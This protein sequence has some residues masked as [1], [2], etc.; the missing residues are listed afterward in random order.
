[1]KRLTLFILLQALLMLCSTVCAESSYVTIGDGTNSTYFYGYGAG[2]YSTTQTIYTAEEI[3]KEGYITAL[4][5]NVA[6]ASAKTTTKLEIYLGLTLKEAFEDANDGL[7]ADELTLVYSGNPTLGST[8]GWNDHVF[9]TKFLFDGTS[10]LVVVV[11]RE[12]SSNPPECYYSNSNGKKNLYRYDFYSKTYSELQ[13]LDGYYTSSSRQNTRFLIEQFPTITVNNINY[14]VTSEDKKTV[15]VAPGSYSGIVSIPATVTYNGNSYS[16][17]SV[18]KDA[19]SG[20]TGLTY[21]VLGNN[22]KTIGANAFKG[23]TGLTT[24]KLPTQLETIGNYAFYDCQNCN[25]SALS[26]KEGL[27]SIGDFAFYNCDKIVSISMPSTLTHL[28]NNAFQN[29]DQLETAIL[30]DALNNISDYCFE[31]CTN[32]STLHLPDNALSIGNSAFYCCSK[33]T[34]IDIPFSV[35]TIGDYALNSTGLSSLIVPSNVTT[36]GTRAFYSS[37]L[38]EVTIDSPILE[39]NYTRSSYGANTLCNFFGNKVEK[40]IIGD[41][42]TRIGNYAFYSDYYDGNKCLKEV[43]MG[44]NIKEVGDYAFSSC[45]AIEKVYYTSLESLCSINFISYNSNPAYYNTANVYIAGEELVGDLII[46]STITSI[47]SYAFYKANI[48]SVNIPSSVISIGKEAFY[49]CSNLSKL[50]IDSPD[51][52]GQDYESYEGIIGTLFGYKITEVVIGNTPTKIGKKAFYSLTQNQLASVKFGNNIREI[53]ESAFGNRET[54]SKVEF[55]SIAALCETTFGNN[56]ANP[57]YCAKNLY[58]NGE[59]V[60]NAVIPDGVTSISNYAFYNAESIRSIDIP[61]SVTSIG[62]ASFSGCSN[63]EDIYVHWQYPPVITGYGGKYGNL[64]VPIGMKSNYSTKNYWKSFTIIADQDYKTV[65]DIQFSELCYRCEIGEI[66]QVEFS[67]YPEDALIKDVVIESDGSSAIYFD[68]NTRQFVGLEDGVATITV[69]SRDKDA[70]S[71]SIKI[72]V[73][74]VPVEDAISLDRNSLN[75]RVGYND[76]LTVSQITTNGSDKPV[77]WTSSNTSVATVSNGVVTG[78]GEGIATITASISGGKSATCT[79][80]VY[81]LKTAITDGSSNTYTN[82]TTE[83]YDQISYTRNYSNTKW[84]SLYVPFTMRYEDWKDEYD[85]AYI[86]SVRQYDNDNDG[87]IDETIMDV[88]QIT[89]GEL[90][91]NMPYMIRA[92]STGSKTITL[93]N[94]ILYQTEVNSVSC[95]TILSEFTF[96][97]TYTTIDAATMLSNNYYAMGGG[98]LIK[99]NGTSSL[100]PFRW[101][102]GIT[103]RSPIYN[104]ETDSPARISINVIGEDCDGETSIYEIAREEECDEDLIFNLNGQK[105]DASESLKPGLYI[106]NGKKIMIK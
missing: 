80:T 54:L 93:N 102:M 77:T 69:T 33:L 64:H 99:T 10:N 89:G 22:I 49:N 1:M 46:P 5:Y 74:N 53:G 88:L 56:T 71:E 48:T 82:S 58:I 26:L 94:A 7:T 19:F 86:N 95:S 17:T 15:S 98:G 16:V 31:R 21:V 65:S 12:S 44:K 6:T 43:V 103:S 4:A 2:Y 50:Y 40:Y 63:L 72:Y 34:H 62:S 51:I 37:S 91:P 79:V 13:N 14:T 41:T 100:K 96:T 78:V 11:C 38:K 25:F 32:L 23:C 47:G 84:Q 60:E 87:V 66:G 24:V 9:Q 85:V 70:Y 20:C 67:L 45:D 68:S 76:V 83:I 18:G 73:G 75:L 28:G 59:L 39:K 97:G 52:L 92:K 8:T 90:Y 81:M 36:V 3:G 105:L 35:T 104:A 42:P 61:M 106:K 29:C 55:S 57:L 27:T 30:S 101:Y